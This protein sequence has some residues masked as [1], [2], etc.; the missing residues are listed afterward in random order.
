MNRQV[1]LWILG[2]FECQIDIAENGEQALEKLKDPSNHY[3]LVFMDYEMT[4]KDGFL[5]THEWRSYEQKQQLQRLPIIA[6]MLEKWIKTQE[7]EGIS[8]HPILLT[9]K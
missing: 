1:T 9:R 3:R 7:Q 4:I 6:L 2:L 8:A 5:A